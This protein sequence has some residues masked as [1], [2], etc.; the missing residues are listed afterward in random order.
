MVVMF[1]S[2]GRNGKHILIHFGMLPGNEV[3]YHSV[4]TSCVVVWGSCK[5][6]LCRS[7]PGRC[8]SCTSC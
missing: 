7:V 1:G 8:D 3:E 4:V 5:H 2:A 6:Q